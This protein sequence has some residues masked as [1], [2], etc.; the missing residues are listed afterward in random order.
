[1]IFT[2]SHTS[3][4]RSSGSSNAAK[5][6]PRGMWVYL[7][8]LWYLSCTRG[9]GWYAN[10]LG[11][12]AHA[13]GVMEGILKTEWSIHK[14][15]ESLICNTWVHYIMPNALKAYLIRSICTVKEVSWK[16]GGLMSS[17]ASSKKDLKSTNKKLTHGAVFF[18]RKW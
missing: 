5:W 1:M 10:S 9:F 2:D 14:Y 18:L 17:L 12:T 13:V 4:A 8:R 11:N 16:L 3:S 15:T 6:P 7:T